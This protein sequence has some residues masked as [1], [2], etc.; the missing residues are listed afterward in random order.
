MSKGAGAG[1]GRKFI[2]LG[3]V[4]GPYNN[5]PILFSPDARSKLI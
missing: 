5:L 1:K 4:G 2:W 3:V